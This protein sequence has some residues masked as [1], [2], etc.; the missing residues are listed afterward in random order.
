MAR[1]SCLENMLFSSSVWWCI[2]LRNWGWSASASCHDSKFSGY[3]FSSSWVS[4]NFS[5]LAVLPSNATMNPISYLDNFS[6]T[7][8]MAELLLDTT[9]TVLPRTRILAMMF[10]IVWVF[11]VPGGP[12]TTLI[13]FSKA[14][15]TAFCWLAL[16]PKGKIKVEAVWVCILYFWG[17]RYTA[18]ALLFAMKWIFSYCFANSFV[19]S[20]A[21][22]SFASATFF[23][24]SNILFE[25]LSP[26][27]D[28]IIS[29]SFSL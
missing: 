16:Q 20:S 19:P 6:S 13:W 9:W 14:A 17:F 10:R 22:N 18:I 23:K 21:F 27:H 7:L 4:M 29:K 15:W 11:P 28:S 5:L 25:R 8:T 1:R 26:K 24:Y 3:C 2:W 12:C